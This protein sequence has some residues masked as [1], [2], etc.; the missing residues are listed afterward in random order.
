MVVSHILRE[1]TKPYTE[2]PSSDRTLKP[3]PS[4]NESDVLPL[5]CGISS[6]E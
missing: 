4:E 6:N 5:Y 1:N 3:G 2:Y